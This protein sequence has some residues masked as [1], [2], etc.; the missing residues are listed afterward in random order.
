V[1]PTDVIDEDCSICLETPKAGDILKRLPCM[2][3]FHKQVRDHASAMRSTVFLVLF[4]SLK[5]RNIMVLNDQFHGS[6]CELYNSE[7]AEFY[8][9]CITEEVACG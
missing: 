3:A 9:T 8:I 1:Q 6:Y 7:T 5:D 4:Q 2:H